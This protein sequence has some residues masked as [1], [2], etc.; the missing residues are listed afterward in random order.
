MTYYANE[1]IRILK[2]QDW[3]KWD[4]FVLM[5]P[6]GSIYHTTAWMR[7]VQKTFKHEPLYIYLQENGKIHACLPLFRIR[8][9]ITGERLNCL[10]A[11]A[12]CDPL[13]DERELSKMMEYSQEQSGSG[14]WVPWEIRTDERFALEIPFRSKQARNYVTHLLDLERP[15]EEIW[16]SFHPGQV[17]RSIRKALRS[18]IS[19]VKGCDRRHVLE[20]YKLY[21]GMRKKNGLL[22]VPT[23]FF[24][25]LWDEFS[26]RGEIE[27]SLARH[28]SRIVAG[29]L[30]LKYRDVVK[31]EYGATNTAALK[32][33]PNQLLLWQSIEK[34]HAGG[35]RW[36]DFGRTRL[37]NKGLLSFKDRWG[38][39]RIPLVYH[40]A[41]NGTGVD[42]LREKRIVPWVMHT[43]MRNSPDAMCQW[44]GSLLYRHTM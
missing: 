24:L 12:V 18:D 27:I 37:D 42:S 26:P 15:L 4:Q 22:P 35:Y 5:H 19:M 21:L 2:E 36:F 17:V 14:D 23:S 3:E 38:T 31:Y 11:A 1:S 34:S 41:P 39:R 8:S 25:N 44:L 20:F 10:P 16:K 28:K 30:L 6:R 29:V 7:V 13:A 33:R 43:L 40:Q 32:I 9:W